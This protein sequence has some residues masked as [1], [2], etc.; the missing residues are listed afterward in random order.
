[1]KVKLI[2]ESTGY[3]YTANVTNWIVEDPENINTALRIKEEA[4]VEISD[5]IAPHFHNLVNVETGEIVSRSFSLID[6]T[7]EDVRK[8]YKLFEDNTELRTDLKKV[9]KNK[10]ENKD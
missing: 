10:K 5:K 7:V 4:V 6:I 1:M 3:G 8:K 2:H 9:F